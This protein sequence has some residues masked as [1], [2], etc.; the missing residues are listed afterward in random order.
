MVEIQ[1]KIDGVEEI[2]YYTIQDEAGNS[3]IS[4]ERKV[5]ITDSFTYLDFLQKE[6]GNVQISCFDVNKDMKYTAYFDTLKYEIY[7]IE[8]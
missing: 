6:L 4:E 1:L 5:P 7:V 3:L 8:E 2:Q